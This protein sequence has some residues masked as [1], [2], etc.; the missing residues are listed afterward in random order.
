MT[1]WI[2]AG[3][4]RPLPGKVRLVEPSAFTRVSALG[5]E[6]QRVRVIADV[7]ALATLGDGY[8]VETR[9]I[10]WRGAV[11]AIP[12][13][14]LFRDRDAWAVY[15][16]EDGRARLRHVTIGHRGRSD[17]EVLDGVAVGSRVISHPNDRISDGTRIVARRGQP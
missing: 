11:V 9:V 5:V 15:V 16:V 7:D 8:R 12:S 14:A 3:G 17:V 6:E 1:V 13:S 4:D 10:T 2:D